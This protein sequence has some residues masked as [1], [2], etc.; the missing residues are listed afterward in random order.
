[1]SAYGVVR[2][3]AWPPRDECAQLPSTPS[4]PRR[5]WGDTRTWWEG[6]VSIDRWG[7]SR[8]EGAPL[9]GT[10]SGDRPDWGTTRTWWEGRVSIDR[11]TCYSFKAGT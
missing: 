5:E 4:G 6:W 11:G 1:M 2:E 3:V 8:D 9:P 10:P 7:T